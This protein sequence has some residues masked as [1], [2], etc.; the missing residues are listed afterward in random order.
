MPW[1]YLIFVLGFVHFIG[2]YYIEVFGEVK[3]HI[4]YNKYTLMHTKWIYMGHRYDRMSYILEMMCLLI[5]YS[6]FVY[7]YI[8]VQMLADLYNLS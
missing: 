7:S 5:S 6:G 3:S 2:K 4:Y 8:L 1:V